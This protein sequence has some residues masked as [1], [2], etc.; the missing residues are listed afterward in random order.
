MEN[1]I[2]KTLKIVGL[3]IST[4]RALK[5][6]VGKQ[7]LTIG[8]AMNLIALD[9]LLRKKEITKKEYGEYIREVTGK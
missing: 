9:F 7:G 5:G 8:K 4:Y 3:H 1:E 2:F 6:Y